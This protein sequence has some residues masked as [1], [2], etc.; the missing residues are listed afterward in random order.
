MLVYQR[1]HPQ[2]RSILCNSSCAI[3]WEDFLIWDRKGTVCPKMGDTKYPQTTLLVG[4]IK[5]FIIKMWVHL[6][7][8][9][10]SAPLKR[11]EKTTIFSRGFLWPPVLLSAGPQRRH[12]CQL[13]QRYWSQSTLFPLWEPEPGGCHL[14][15]QLKN[16]GGFSI[17]H[18][19]FHAISWDLLLMTHDQ[20]TYDSLSNKV[21]DRTDGVQSS[22]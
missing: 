6:S 3:W 9:F 20:E 5:F 21:K 7:F 16:V 1:I 8:Q 15:P 18:R 17:F 14:S 19:I 12:C 2:F 10:S 22:E 4:Q 11:H 13:S